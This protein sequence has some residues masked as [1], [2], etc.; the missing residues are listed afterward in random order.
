[1]STIFESA[2][3]RP[4]QDLWECFDPC[5]ACPQLLGSRALGADEVRTLKKFHACPLSLTILV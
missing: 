4:A 2:R 1:M 3:R 5:R